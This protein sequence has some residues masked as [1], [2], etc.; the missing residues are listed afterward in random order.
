MAEPISPILA[1]VAA[2]S[3]VV[4]LMNAIIALTSSMQML[5]TNVQN[6][7]LIKTI[8]DLI[9]RIQT[10]A[11]KMNSVEKDRSLLAQ[12]VIKIKK[13]IIKIQGLPNKQKQ[14][15]VDHL[16]QFKEI[17][18]DVET[19]LLNWHKQ[20]KRCQKLNKRLDSAILDY[21]FTRDGDND[22]QQHSWWT[23]LKVNAVVIGCA[24]LLSILNIRNCYAL[25]RKYC[26]PQLNQIPH[27]WYDSAYLYFRKIFMS[28]E[29]TARSTN[30][31]L[32]SVCELVIWSSIFSNEATVRVQR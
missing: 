26:Q 5:A 19:F 9:A 2:A 20:S 14:I 24:S 11:K 10:I 21:G 7:S 6:K 18:K 16:I 29:T 31:V 1:V 32:Q 28:D 4:G 15:Y 30:I 12:R 17:F 3:A 22:N 13:D 8:L 27:P 23:I 25:F